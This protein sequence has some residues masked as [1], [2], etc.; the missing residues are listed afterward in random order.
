MREYAQLEELANI[1][2]SFFQSLL[3]ERQCE[4]DGSEE[5]SEE[6]DN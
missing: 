1:Q 3:R 5:S 2:T 6:C 4:R